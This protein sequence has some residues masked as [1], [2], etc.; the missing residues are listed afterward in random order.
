MNKNR[1]GLAAVPLALAALLAPGLVHSAAAAEP[2]IVITD[3]TATP[4]VE[5]GSYAPSWGTEE[6]VLFTDPTP[7]PEGDV[8]RVRD[9]DGDGYLFGATT[10]DTVDGND[11]AAAF[12]ADDDRSTWHLRVDQLRFDGD[13]YTVVEEGAPFTYERPPLLEGPDLGLVTQDPTARPSSIDPPGTKIELV[14]GRS[15]FITYRGEWEAGTSFI[16][17]VGLVRGS[18]GQSLYGGEPLPETTR[19]SVLLRSEGN[20]VSRF[21]LPASAAGSYLTVLQVGTKP[22]R[23]AFGFGFYNVSAGF[24][25]VA[26]QPTSW[27]RSYGERSGPARAGRAVSISAPELSAAGRKA[28][29][30]FTY[31]WTIGGKSVAGATKRTFAVPRGAK[32]K[33]VAVTVFSS[34]SGY[35][36]LRRTISFGKA[37]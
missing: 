19:G 15:V 3:V 12:L 9:L 23:R 5:S 24:R 29:L 18:G 2:G 35:E 20:R 11:G 13:Q 8:Y 7:A 26:P 30:R 36:T 32:G 6:T 1:A 27:V 14:A 4:Y 10:A 25:V 33:A 22:G 17:N 28:R 34:K 31:R 21:D 16:T 37:R